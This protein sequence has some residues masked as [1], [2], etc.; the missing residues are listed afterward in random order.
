VKAIA[1]TGQSK[2]AFPGRQPRGGHSPTISP[3][4]AVLLYLTLGSF[5]AANIYQSTI[6]EQIVRLK[7]AFLIVLLG[8]SLRDATQFP[9]ARASVNLPLALAILAAVSLSIP[10]SI[11]IEN[12]ALLFTSVALA[13]V[14]A[15]Y[16]AG[17]LKN[18]E[19][20]RYFFN[21]VANVGKLVIASSLAMWLLGLNLGRVEEDRFSGWIDNPNTLGFLVVP[22]LVIL[23]CKV[24]ERGPRREIVNLAFLLSGLFILQQTGSRASML[25][26][27]CSFLALWAFRKGLG[28]LTFAAYLGLIVVFGW[29][30]EISQ[31]LLNFISRD[32]SA[33]S[34]GSDILSGRSELWGLGLRLFWEKPILGYGIGSSQELVRGYLWIFVESQ[35]LHFHNSYLTVLVETGCVGFVALMSVLIPIVARGIVE[36]GN[37]Q[38]VNRRDWPLIALPWVMVI[39]A[40]AHGMFE[41]WFLSAGNANTFVLWT[42]IWLTRNNFLRSRHRKI[43]WFEPRGAL[44]AG[45]H[46]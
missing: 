44:R 12:S 33:L 19:A 29:W 43:T 40:L 45:W 37:P 46:R 20:Q 41:S 17:N 31:L 6:A 26:V 8:V 32:T 25:W 13:I 16:V 36:A 34:Q 39:G 38:L 10:G 21:V 5:Y 4:A 15:C 1:A 2:P 30:T 14:A 42:C 27:A 35:G 23:L 24:V 7:W 18:L 9:P 3:L 22:T 28:L 11:D